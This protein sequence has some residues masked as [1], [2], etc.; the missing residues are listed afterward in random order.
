MYALFIASILPLFIGISVVLHFL[1]VLLCIINPSFSPSM[2]ESAVLP[3]GSPGSREYKRQ[4]II[5]R[6]SAKFLPKAE[7]PVLDGMTI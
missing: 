2:S 1:V 7:L 4:Q 6:F 3:D 5:W